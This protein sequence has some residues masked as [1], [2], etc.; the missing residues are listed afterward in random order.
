VNAKYRRE[1][2]VGL[3]AIAIAVLGWFVV[4]PIGIDLPSQIDISALAPD[5]WP[6]VVMLLL[7]AAGIAIVA[8]GAYDARH[9][10]VADLEAAEEEEAIEHPFAQ[11]AARVVFALAVMFAFYVAILEVGIVVSSALVIVVFTYALGYRQWRHIL[12]LA[13]LLPVL[14]YV[15]F[16][17][18]ASV[19]MPLGVFE[20]L[21]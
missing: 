11:L 17:H 13:V 9:P 5:F 20:A 18:V 6:R 4:I 14:L 15:F 19:P 3:A 16:V 1:I 10:P 8:Q 7:A 2:G 12:P 21:L